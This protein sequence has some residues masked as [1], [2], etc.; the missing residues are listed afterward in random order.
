MKPVP[1][2]VLAAAWLGTLA[3]AYYF[4]KS[5]APSADAGSGG[6]GGPGSAAA[7]PSALPGGKPLPGGQEGG[8]GGAAAGSR[9][10]MSVR[11]MVA[12]GRAEMQKSMGMMN[13]SA[14]LRAL[15]PFADLTDEEVQEAITEIE[16]TVEQPQ[17]KMMFYSLLVGRWAESD[18]AAAMAFVEEELADGGPMMGGVKY[19][20]VSSWAQN[21]PD[22]AWQWYLKAKQEEDQGMF[23]GPSFALSGIF[24][25]YAQR[26]L[27]GA[28]KKLEGLDE[29][30]RMMA[31]GGFA[32]GAYDPEFRERLLGKAAEMEDENLRRTL[33]QGIS[34]QW[35]MMDPE[36]AADWAVGLPD[37]DR[38]Q[39]AQS[40]GS[41]LMMSSKP[42][43]GAD[44]MVSAAQTEQEKAQAYSSAVAQWVHRDANA[45]GAW[46]GK[47]PQGPELDQ[48]RSTFASSIAGRDPESA[49]AWAKTITDGGQR[50][51]A[52]SQVY[53]QWYRADAAAAETALGASG[54]A[55]DQIEQIRKS[56]PPT[57]TE[58]V[59]TDAPVR[60]E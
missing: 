2:T 59:P 11:E 29:N 34:S 31:A 22:G 3:G 19:G 36:G 44:L 41:S 14:I 18:G 16:R 58:G 23:G 51:G 43:K 13:P 37:A 8:A 24:A 47:Q 5:A 26:D 35:A 39:V 21:D 1:A 49:M 56:A 52:V 60:A 53:Q 55:P 46:L 28:F 57:P 54:L 27:D 9:R 48:A 12:L 17:A 7:F 33:Y 40:V 32:Q 38:A 4:G 10:K 15:A 42:E 20:V 45:A 50:Q 30:E 6:S 25:S